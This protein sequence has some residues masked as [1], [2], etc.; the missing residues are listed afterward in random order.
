MKTGR[1]AGQVH[2]AVELAANIIVWTGAAGLAVWFGILLWP[3]L[4]RGPL[5]VSILL[6]A[7]F[8][9]WLIHLHERE[10]RARPGSPWGGL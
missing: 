6:I 1:K 7:F 5:V 2:P 10:D 3:Q 8:A 9:Y 4:A